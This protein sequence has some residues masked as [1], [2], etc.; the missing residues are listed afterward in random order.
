MR[1]CITLGELH[2]SQPTFLRHVIYEWSLLKL[3]ILS[4]LPCWNWEYSASSSASA[5]QGSDG[6]L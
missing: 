6:R 3:S 4:F 2:F 1:L 5:M